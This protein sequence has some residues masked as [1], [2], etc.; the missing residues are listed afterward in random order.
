MVKIQ[1]IKKTLACISGE[2]YVEDCQI[3]IRISIY[4][5]G[6]VKT[7]PLPEDYYWCEKHLNYAVAFLKKAM[8]AENVP[9]EKLI[10]WW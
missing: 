8:K 6:E 7:D 1:N 3:P 5:T 10:V 2:A 9:T 4:T